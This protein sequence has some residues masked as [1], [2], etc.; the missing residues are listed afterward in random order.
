MDLA[1]FERINRTERSARAYLLDKNTHAVCPRC[2]SRR[3][4]LLKCGRRRCASCRYTF[5][6]LTGRWLNHGAFSSRQWLRAVKLFELDVAAGP[7]AAQL[8]VTYKT[9]HR[10]FT[11]I[12]RA[13][14]ARSPNAVGLLAHASEWIFGY[15]TEGL[16]TVLRVVAPGDVERIATTRLSGV[17]AGPL[18]LTGPYRRWHG[19]ILQRRH[20]PTLGLHVSALPQAGCGGFR[21]YVAERVRRYRG[22]SE[23]HLPLYL[24]EMEFR[25]NLRGGDLFEA[26]V[27]HLRMAVPSWTED[28]TAL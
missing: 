17:A 9:A 28:A 26:V 15:R 22:I 16:R 5:H 3:S 24:M 18:A 12:R 2:T 4:Y 19:L 8:G 20:L 10:A 11:T 25:F 23:R 21:G 7:A 6:A 27:A 13:I 14:A 1:T